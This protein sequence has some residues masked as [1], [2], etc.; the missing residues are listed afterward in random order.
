MTASSFLLLLATLATAEAW[1]T[2]PSLTTQN[3][4]FQS[5]ASRHATLLQMSSE[6]E[7]KEINFDELLDMDIVL[8]S[9]RNNDD[10]QKQEL[11]AVQEDGTVVPISVWTLEPAYDT[12]LEFVV[13]EVDRFPGL[14]ADTVNIVE[15][16]DEGVIGYGSRQ[17]FGGK[18]PGNPHGEES[19]Q[20][21]YVEQET[22]ESRAVE[23][24]VKPELEIQW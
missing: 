10:S 2:A 18:G 9:R 22:L 21:Y 19:E 24:V 4:C 20:L 7:Q 23:I 8:F 5:R 1:V 15:I 13:D 11:G 16:L 12:S 14:T 17:L 6:I 3:F